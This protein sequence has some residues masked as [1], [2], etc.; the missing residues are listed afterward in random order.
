MSV[1]HLPSV[2]AD[3]EN[4]AWRTFVQGLLLDVAAAVVAVLVVALTDVEWTLTYW[5]ALG[6]VLLKTVLTA[7]VSYAARRITPPSPS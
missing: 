5:Q 7:A 2:Q 4:R 6:L 1:P 3:A